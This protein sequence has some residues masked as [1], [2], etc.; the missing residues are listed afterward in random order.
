MV[1]ICCTNQF[2]LINEEVSTLTTV[3]KQVQFLE[4]ILKEDQDVR[5]FK[6]E[7]EQRFGYNSKEYQKALQNMLETDPLN[8][9]KIETY[10]KTYG[11][12][13]IKDHG[14]DAAY[15]PWLVIHHAQGGAEPRERNFK[16]LYEGY[17]NGGLDGDQL[18]FFLNR[19]HDKKFG[20][21][22]KWGGTYRAEEELDTLFKSLDLLEIVTEIDRKLE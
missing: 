20:Y 6:T 9:L 12:P 17:K 4:A 5:H 14:K 16:Y 21:R 13:T 11:Y 22:I 7:Q 1:L 2:K 15:A 19:L 10:L 8:L 18:A 3:E